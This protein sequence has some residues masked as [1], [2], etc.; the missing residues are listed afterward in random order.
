MHTNNTL[1]TYENILKKYTFLANLV[2][3][4]FFEEYLVRNY[5]EE[6]GSPR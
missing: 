4:D 6:S 3:G 2:E 1:L 5:L